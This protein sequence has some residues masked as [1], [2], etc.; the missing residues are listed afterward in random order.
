MSYLDPY[1]ISKLFKLNH[2]QLDN[3]LR[4][5]KER[6]DHD[7]EHFRLS[8]LAA[9]NHLNYIRY[10]ESYPNDDFKFIF[11]EKVNASKA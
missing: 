8:L 6:I 3:K 5:L 1:E 4:N 10:H 9:L 11:K 7:F 2:L